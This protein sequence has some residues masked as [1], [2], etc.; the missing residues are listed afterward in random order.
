[1]RDESVQRGSGYIWLGGGGNVQRGS[2]WEGGGNVQISVVGG[3]GGGSENVQRGSGWGGGVFCTKKVGV[4]LGDE[5]NEIPLYF[6]WNSRHP[7]N[8]QKTSLYKPRPPPPPPLYIS[9]GVGIQMSSFNCIHVKK[10]PPLHPYPKM[11]G[12]LLEN[13]QSTRPILNEAYL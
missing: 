1:M 2:G 8:V 7:N 4:W 9:K 6:C 5:K 12:A 11:V 13:N 3:W 10:L